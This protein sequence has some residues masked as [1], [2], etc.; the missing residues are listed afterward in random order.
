[1]DNNLFKDKHNLHLEG[2]EE[3]DINNQDLVEVLSSL[4]SAM[5]KILMQC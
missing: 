5:V 4:D 3:Q 2:A 1:M